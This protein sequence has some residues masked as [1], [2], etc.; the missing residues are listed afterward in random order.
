[1]SKNPI[2]MLLDEN[3]NEP[4]TLFNENNKPVSFEQI[5]IVPING[6]IYVILK[7]IGEFQ[8]VAEDEALVFTIQEMDQEDILM[9]VDD[10]AT[11]DAVFK[12]YYDLL[13]EAGIS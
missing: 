10:D 2:D 3:N 4:I 13:S 11:I 7:P 1:M 5:A 12:E 9:L 8:G 6:A